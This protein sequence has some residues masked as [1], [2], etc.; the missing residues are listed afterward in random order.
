M[1]IYWKAFIIYIE[2][3][4]KKATKRELAVLLKDLGNLLRIFP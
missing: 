3:L 1:V 2:N 4:N